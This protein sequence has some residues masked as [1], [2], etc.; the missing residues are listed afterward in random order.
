M[1]P[2]AIRRA[3]FFI[4]P[5]FPPLFVLAVDSIFLGRLG[6]FAPNRL[7][8]ELTRREPDRNQ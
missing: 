3:S 6:S 8:R 2:D 5:I 4:W 1:K 7:H